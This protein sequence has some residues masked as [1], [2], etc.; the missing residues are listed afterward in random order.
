MSKNLQDRLLSEM[1]A[2]TLVDPHT[3]IQ[4]LAPASKTFADLL[5]YHYYTELVHSAG[6]P[7]EVIENPQL[8]PKEKI[9]LLAG[10]LPA[11]ANTVQYS[12]LLEIAHELLG[13]DVPAI[14]GAQWETVANHAEKK[15][16]ASHWVEE[17][18]AKSKLSAVFLTND[19][20]DPLQGF[21]TSK[22][23][24]CLRVDDLV[25][26]FAKQS[27]QERLETCTGTRPHNLAT[28]RT[29]LESLFQRFHL[30]G[31]RACA[32]ST[33]PGFSPERPDELSLDGL[34]SRASKASE[35]LGAG[36]EEALARGIFWEVTKKCQ[37]YRLP[38]DLMIGV[39][40]RV[41]PAGVYKGQDLYD[42]PVSLIQYA[43][44]FS[45]FPSVTFPLSVLASVTNQ[46]LV[47]YGWIF[48]NVAA[49]GHWWY[50]N[51][52]S[53]IERDLEHRLEA[54]P[55]GKIIGYYSD[56]YKLE[57][58]LPKFNMYKR[59]LAKVLAQRFV[60]DRNWKEEQA[61]ALAYKVLRSNVQDIFGV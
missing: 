47:S 26:H 6:T 44:L 39:L 32:I 18:L 33:P 5:G 41:Y 15:M 49:N 11:L 48:P 36:E 8:A 29:A 24:P 19:F 43:Q 60:I 2:W 51:T 7:R 53:I 54:M 59:I 35:T 52:P 13:L 40:R 23:I 45:A 42:S 4:A 31:A 25:F 30:A 28:L 55:A 16:Q 61:L 46:E 58:A 34:I 14:D 3:H 10:K 1:Q 37:D 38:F 9:K 57:F 12:W 22:Y 20:D 27:T 17:V 50:S 56:M 21:D